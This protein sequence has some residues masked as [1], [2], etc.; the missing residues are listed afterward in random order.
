MTPY[1]ATSLTAASLMLA[2][3][4]TMDAMGEQTLATANLMRADGVQVGTAQVL[5]RGNTLSVAVT[6]TAA[7]SGVHG[8]HLHTTGQCTAPDFTSAGGHLNPTDQEHGT[9]NPAGAHFGDLPNLRVEPSGRG[10]LT[11]D[12]SGT[13][14][15]VMEW[16]FDSDGTAVMIH[17][18]PDDYRTE[19]AG[20]A[21]SRIACG[22]L[23]RS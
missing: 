19:P 11:A 14:Q 8:F 5:E 23:M 7:P 12:L 22:V 3:C 18:G 13:H 2:G 9:L 6:T 16:L 10:S 1:L 4:S 15:Q 21:G 20:A 17:S